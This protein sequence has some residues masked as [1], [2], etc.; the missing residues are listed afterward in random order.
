MQ[1]LGADHI[2]CWLGVPLIA[3]DRVVGIYSIDRYLPGSLTA[4]DARLAETLAATAA[5]AIERALLF[6]QLQDE[7]TLLA[8]RVAERTADLSL[9]N[10]ELARAARLKDEFLAN[11][12]HELRTPL[13]AI[14][15]RAEAL[16]EAIYGPV[17]P[18]QTETLH[19]I[20][21]S[22]QHLLSM[23][24]D[25]LDLSKIEAGR[26]VV[27][28]DTL[29]VAL[30][31]HACLRM[32]TQIAQAKR[33]SI[34]YDID[35]RVETMRA[36]ERR[37]KQILVNLLSNAVKFTP[38]GGAVGLEVRGDGEWQAVTF[39]V[40]DTGIGIAA[41]DL[42]KLFEPF[43]QVDSQL[44]RAYEGTGLG[45]ALVLQ[46]TQAHGGSVSVE[47]TP[48]QGSRFS[49][50]LPWIAEGRQADDTP[51][52]AAADQPLP[53]PDPPP[54]TTGPG[55]LT[56]ARP[57]ILLAEDNEAN[58]D[59]LRDHLLAKGYD[60]TVAR[61]GSEAVVRAQEERPD[62]I[63]MDIQMPGM[64]GLEAIRRLRAEPAMRAIPI[65]ALTA[66]AMPGDR[67]RC[68]SAGADD[69]LSKPVS[70]RLLQQ[71]IDAHLQRGRQGSEPA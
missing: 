10:A 22:G 63:L 40:W 1:M 59:T 47:S 34:T 20:A 37:L 44:A 56:R 39:T 45:L 53:E 6:A 41:D 69:Y 54:V 9:A 16:E 3:S 50:T 27:A 32:I 48:G 58:I 62:V 51:A 21:E 71:T 60:I 64:D 8:Q 25:I 61:N 18:R 17:T 35:M 26:F 15:T 68:L 66:L 46:L 52:A 36:D 19:G 12:S 4:Q 30:L 14:L 7:R 29:D 57:R 24:N 11:M 55:N 42:P 70:L 2:R 49:V 33:V 5:T 65:L 13:N 31:C 43:V 23:I 38:E 28:Y 67:E